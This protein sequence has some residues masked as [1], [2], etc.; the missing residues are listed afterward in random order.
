MD[1]K[2]IILIII[3]LF[4]LVEG[5]KPLRQLLL[6]YIVYSFILIQNLNTVDYYTLYGHT[7]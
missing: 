7:T 3:K 4:V 6:K 2:Y 5:N 1:L